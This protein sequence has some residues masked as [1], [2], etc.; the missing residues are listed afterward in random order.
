MEIYTHFQIF[1]LK[2]NIV[3]IR[4]KEVRLHAL[5]RYVFNLYF[6]LIYKLIT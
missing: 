2:E 4:P 3:K 1:I 5:S 6:R